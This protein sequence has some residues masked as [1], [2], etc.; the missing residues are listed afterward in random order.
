MIF[1]NEAHARERLKANYDDAHAVN[2]KYPACVTRYQI[3]NGY[4]IFLPEIEISRAT[5]ATRSPTF[6]YCKF[7]III[8]IIIIT[9][10]EKSV[11]STNRNLRTNNASTIIKLYYNK[12]KL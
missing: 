5:S 4:G 12:N 10:R 11:V 1:D 3:A 6:C 9:L 8:I 2:Y 7:V